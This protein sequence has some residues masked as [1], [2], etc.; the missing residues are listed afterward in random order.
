ML[1]YSLW[2]WTDTQTCV[3]HFSVTQ[4]SDAALEVL[5]AA[6]SP[7]SP[8]PWQPGT[9]G[10][11]G[12]TGCLCTAGGHVHGADQGWGAPLWVWTL[13]GVPTEAVCMSC[14]PSVPLPLLCPGGPF[15]LQGRGASAFSWGSAGGQE[16]G[17]G[18]SQTAVTLQLGL[19][20]DLE[21]LTSHF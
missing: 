10:N 20:S 4:R 14:L 16:Q 12:Q 17:E 7:P 8:T 11:A 9:L 1:L 5:G 2:V 13:R 21:Q 19:G 6:L 3:H 18:P 15:R